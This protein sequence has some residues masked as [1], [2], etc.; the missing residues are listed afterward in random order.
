MHEE[1]AG[2]EDGE[3]LPR[4]HDGGEE[5]GAVASDGVGDEELPGRGGGG[6]EEDV[7]EG[8]GVPRD[9]RQGLG[10]LAR[11]DQA[12]WSPRG[13]GRGGQRQ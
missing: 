11:G 3:E 10:E 5:E 4:G 6:E 2:E 7:A 13:R 12:C 9:E 1:G 8:L